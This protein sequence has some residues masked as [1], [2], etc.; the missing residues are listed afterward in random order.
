MYYNATIFVSNVTRIIV[1]G[2]KHW[3]SLSRILHISEISFSQ[4]ITVLNLLI[5]ECVRWTLSE[6]GLFVSLPHPWVDP[7]K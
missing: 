6:G 4:P 1:S 7:L 3:R 5:V 2:E